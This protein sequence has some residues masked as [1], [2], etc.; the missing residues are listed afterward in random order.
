[1]PFD[2]EPEMGIERD[3]SVIRRQHSQTELFHG[4]MR[5]R[6]LDQRLKQSPPDA[7]PAPFLVDGE[8]QHSSMRQPSAFAAI[9]EEGAN[10][11]SGNFGH[12]TK[13]A[14]I[15]GILTNPVSFLFYGQIEFIGLRDG[16]FSLLDH[17]P[18]VNQ[19]GSG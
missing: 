2:D 4:G 19:K 1:S 14:R 8:M 16:E 6:P 7:L 3:C 5:F 9:K 15:A 11:L 12:Q 17:S 18:S 10:H 13:L